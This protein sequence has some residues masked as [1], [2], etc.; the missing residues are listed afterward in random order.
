M[1]PISTFV[2]KPSLPKALQGLEALAYNL[3][4]AWD[5]DTMDLFRPRHQDLNSICETGLIT[6]A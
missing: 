5:P 3:R 1:K 2:V 6:W 4:W